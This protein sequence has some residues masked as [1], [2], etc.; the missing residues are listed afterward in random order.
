MLGPDDAEY[1]RDFARRM[2]AKRNAIVIAVGV[3]GRYTVRRKDTGAEITVM[4]GQTGGPYRV[5]QELLIE[6]DADGGSAGRLPLI[7]GI[8]QSSANGLIP[9]ERT[10]AT[11][12]VSETLT[13]MPAAPVQLMRGGVPR[14]LMFGGYALASAPA[15][16]HASVVNDV[17]AVIDGGSIRVAVKALVGCPL[18]RY[19]LTIAGRLFADYFEVV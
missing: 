6:Q 8:A 9:V 14:T 5:G 16:G 7:L 3:D 13:S 18:G 2:V 1:L 11:T 4:A 15:Y 10:Q 12:V 17:A 19:S